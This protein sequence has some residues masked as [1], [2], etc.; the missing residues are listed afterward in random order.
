MALRVGTPFTPKGAAFKKNK[1]SNT[2]T[3]VYGITLD[4]ENSA[5]P[6]F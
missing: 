3:V 5:V 6:I 4:V 2:G 1:C